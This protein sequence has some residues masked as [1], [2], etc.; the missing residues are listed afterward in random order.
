MFSAEDEKNFIGP[1]WA[2]RTNEKGY[3]EDLKNFTRTY[4]ALRTEATDC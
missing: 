3:A 1:Y 2:L 4:W